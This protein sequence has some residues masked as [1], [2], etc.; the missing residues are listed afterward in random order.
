MKIFYLY[1]FCILGGVTTQL[2]NRLKFLRD[3]CEVHFGF[4]GDYGGR[5]AFEGYDK[6]RIL[7]TVEEIRAYIEAHDFDF[8]ITIDTYELYDALKSTNVSGTVIHEVHTT[9]EHAL[10][11]LAEAK[12]DLPFDY[13]L[14][15]SAYMKE[16]LE[17]MGISGAIAVD[18]CLDMNLF[19][20]D[21]AAGVPE[22]AAPERGQDAS[23]RQREPGQGH[24][25]DA[26]DRDC[27]PRQGL[28]T[29]A[30]G[31]ERESRRLPDS[32]APSGAGFGEPAAAGAARSGQDKIVLWVGKLDAHKNWTSF[33]EVAARLNERRSD[34]KFWLVGGYTAPEEVKRLLREKTEQMG[35]ANLAWIPKIDYDAMY[36]FY[37]AVSSGGGVYVSTSTNESFGMTV[38]EAMACR[39]PAVVPRVGALPELLTGEL[40][41]SLYELNDEEACA[42]RICA[43]LDDGRLRSRLADEGERKARKTY[44]IEAVGAQYLALLERLGSGGP[45]EVKD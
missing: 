33:L 32:G 30:S 15:P 34:L 13:V 22:L 5:V 39:C 25:T 20:F 24:G 29:D 14:T 6:V 11:Q 18:N 8:L 12:D 28:G 19:R 31:R 10:R 26:S 43:L 40:A 45:S 44:G 9:Y 36:R 38:L 2:A 21:P 16:R 23:G 17:E 4:V 42:D 7:P 27:E 37:S 3:R 41:V 1:Q 35:L